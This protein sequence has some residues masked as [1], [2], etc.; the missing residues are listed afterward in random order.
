[1]QIYLNILNLE[2]YAGNIYRAGLK[3]AY[4]VEYLR[5]PIT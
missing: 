4:Q 2:V 3:A 5:N 1:M